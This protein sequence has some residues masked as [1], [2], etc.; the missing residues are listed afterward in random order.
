MVSV[1]AFQVI[2]T[3]E[4]TYELIFCL[5]ELTSNA[6]TATTTAAAS[7]TDTPMQVHISSMCRS[8]TPIH[9]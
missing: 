8:L 4:Q 5:E 1:D 6:T 2:F 7:M 9:V 3:S